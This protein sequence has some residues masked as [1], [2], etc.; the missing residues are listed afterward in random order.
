[1]QHTLR[2][3][4]DIQGTGL[5][6]GKAVHLSLKPAPSGHGV[7]FKR[8]DITGKNPLIPAKWDHVVDT[9]LCTVI[10]NSDGVTVGTIE[11]LMSA[12]RGCGV[13]NVLV[14][15]D[16]PEVPV[17]DGSAAPFVE[18]I[19]EAGLQVQSMPRRAIRIL[20]EITVRD[21]DK[22]VTL[23][24]SAVPVF[25][26]QIDFEHPD[27]GTQR[28]EVKL[29]NGNFKHDIADC[30]TFGFLAEVEAMQAAGL[31]LGGSLE[32]AVVLDESGVINPEGLRCADEFIRHKLLDAIGD[33]YLAGG[34]VLGAYEGIRG[35]HALNNKVLR[36]LFA[37]PSAYEIVDLFVDVDEA[38][39]H[40]Y[41][42]KPRAS[43]V[44]IA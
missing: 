44:A 32:N 5:H 18:R 31:A 11:H 23:S 17:M 42:E 25:S 14:E 8:T 4:I 38:D 20:K 3:K 30:R 34:P 26:G 15:V 24:P 7:V 19:E 12:L 39:G 33:L 28:H 21:G 9:R 2:H 35:G 29:V 6:S 27:V 13:D 1:M 37:D 36:A 43:S 40:V 22:K 10:G 41:P 16:A